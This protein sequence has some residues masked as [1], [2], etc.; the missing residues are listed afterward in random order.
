MCVGFVVGVCGATTT[1]FISDASGAVKESTVSRSQK[2]A[3]EVIE[4]NDDDDDGKVIK[5]C[6][7]RSRNKKKMVVCCCGFL[8]WLFWFV[9]FPI[10]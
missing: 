8:V 6:R 9:P 10:S 1:T 2:Y 3:F 5:R 4:I 7:S